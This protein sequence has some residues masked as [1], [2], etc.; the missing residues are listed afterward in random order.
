LAQ[1]DK[2]WLRLIRYLLDHTLPDNLGKIDGETV[3]NHQDAEVR[4]V[5]AHQSARN[6]D[7]QLLNVDKSSKAKG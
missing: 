2:K 3:R 1:A 7:V 6:Q 4:Q 5:S